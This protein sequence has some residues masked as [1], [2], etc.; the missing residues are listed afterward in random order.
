MSPCSNSNNYNFTLKS[1]INNKWNTDVYISNSSFDFS[2]QNTIS[3]QEQDI[4]TIRMGFNFSNSKVIDKMGA[5]LD[6]SEGIGSSDYSQYGIKLI[7][8]LNLYKNLIMN[9]NLRHYYKNLNVNTSS[10]DSDYQ[11]SIIRASLSYKF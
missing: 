10:S 7:L 2:K 9:I 5:W 11:N 4:S 6:Y 1:Y 3:Y 8:D